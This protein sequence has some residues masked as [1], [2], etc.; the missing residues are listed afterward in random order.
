[1]DYKEEFNI[2]H[3]WFID[4]FDREPNDE[5]IDYHRDR[6]LGEV[7]YLVDAYGE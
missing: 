7:H 2:W 1:M 3:D 6:F 5:E 4:T